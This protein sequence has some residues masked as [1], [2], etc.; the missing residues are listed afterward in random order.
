LGGG[1][2]ITKEELVYSERGKRQSGFT[3]IELIIVI[4]II[5]ILAAIAIPK[6]TNVSDDANNAVANGAAGAAASA[7]SIY[8]AQCH[9]GSS[10]CTAALSD[11][12]VVS[13]LVSV[14]A[15]FTITAASLP[16]TGGTC[17]IGDGTHSA[18]FTA[19]GT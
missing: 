13:N 11:C 8:Y 3:L 16:T 5:G 12:S 7:A 19:I 4:V 6:L 18:T 15:G 9:G 1:S 17:T 10:S 14:P 2:L